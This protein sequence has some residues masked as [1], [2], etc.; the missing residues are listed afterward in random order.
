M[1]ENDS[2]LVFEIQQKV[3]DEKT[4]VVKFADSSNAMVALDK[5]DKINQTIRMRESI[6]RIRSICETD[7]GII[8]YP[9][10]NAILPKARWLSVAAAASYSTGIPI[11]TI[12][13]RS[14]LDRKSI[15][16][17]CGS[18]NNPTSEYL[19]IIQDNVHIDSKGINWLL[20]LLVKDKQ[21]QD[22]TE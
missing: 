10:A 19:T 9:K 12:V 13:E 16:A 14:K 11:D 2:S 5:L 21:I 3:N 18:V 20:N 4:I 7:D 6:L 22:D 8:Y 15:A 17:Y 1:N